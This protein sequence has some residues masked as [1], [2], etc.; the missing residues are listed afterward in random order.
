MKRK[1]RRIAKDKASQH[2][3]FIKDDGREKMRVGD[4]DVFARGTSNGCEVC[5]QPYNYAGT[6]LCG[7]CA[8]GEAETIGEGVYTGE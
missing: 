2:G 7:P 3:R 8:T 5:G 6:G 4:F 1:P